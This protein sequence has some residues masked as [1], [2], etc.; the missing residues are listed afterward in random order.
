MTA[1]GT[2]VA[3]KPRQLD[4]YA[5]IRLRGRVGVPP[6]VEYTLRL[7]RLHRKFHCVLYP[8]ILP[9]ID[10]MLH[11]AKDWITWGEISRDTLIELLRTRGRIPGDK[12]I[13][14][15]YLQKTLKISSIEDLADKLLSGE[16]MLHKLYDKARK[17]WIIKP[18]FRLHPPRGGFRGSIKKP[19][20]AGGELGYRGPAINELIRRML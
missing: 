6:D 10:G 2:A 5:I 7:L 15:E 11:K 19:Y 8:S 18:V 20:G 17:R 3:E 13:T 12:P 14:P 1:V 9:G 4:L 16:I